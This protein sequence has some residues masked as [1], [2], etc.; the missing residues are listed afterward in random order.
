MTEAAERYDSEGEG[1]G[2][3]FLDAIRSTKK[4]IQRNPNLWSFRV[5]P[6]RSCRVQR[7]PYRLHYVEEHDR[8][9]V[10]AVAHASRRPDYWEGRLGREI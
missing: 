5:A 4:R 2:R 10:V 8:I 6:V 1:L 9:I 3:A 7:F